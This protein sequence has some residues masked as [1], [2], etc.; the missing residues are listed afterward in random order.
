MSRWPSA[1]I[2]VLR[3]GRQKDQGRRREDRNREWSDV[4]PHPKEGRWPPEARKDEEIEP[5]HRRQEELRGQRGVLKASLKAKE[6]N[7]LK[8]KSNQDRHISPVMKRKMFLNFLCQQ[9]VFISL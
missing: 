2:S 3:S 6:N 8:F 5:P 7:I 1:I 4:G 9:K